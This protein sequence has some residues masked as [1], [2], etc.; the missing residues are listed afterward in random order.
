MKDLTIKPEAGLPVAM[1]SFE[2]DSGSGFEG[3]GAGDMSIP[4]LKIL[5]KLSPELQRETKVDGAEEG[6]LCNSVTKEVIDGEIGVV[7]IPCAYQKRWVEWKPRT[8]GGGLVSYHDTDEL[9]KTCST[10]DKNK[11]IL[12]NGNTLEP[13]AYYY[14]LIVKEDGS[15][16]PCVMS[17]ASTQMKK[18]KQWN[19]IMQ[20]IK[21]KGAKGLYTPPMYSHRYN[22][23][24][25]REQKNTNSWYGFDI[26]IMG[27]I[28]EQ[29]HYL[30]AKKMNADFQKGTLKTAEEG[31]AL[32]QEAEVM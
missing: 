19:T 31:E 28:Q 4:F 8:S 32:V 26:G 5:Q 11:S 27:P 24:T 12:P 1:T 23:R 15:V 7:V 20:G 22:I 29:A 25:V 14:V 18:A 3:M 13:T 9:L 16:S 10:N 30:A 2:Q 21:L 17:L 6:F